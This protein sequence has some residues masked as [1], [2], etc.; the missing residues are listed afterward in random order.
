[1]IRPPASTDA[2]LSALLEDDPQALYDQAPCGFLSTAPDGLIVKVNQT[3]LRWA[4]FSSGDLV[5]QR[6]FASLLTK[7]GQIYYDTHYEPMLLMQGGVREIALELVTQS[8]QRMPVL[9]NAG[10]VRGPDGEPLV[11]R[12]VVF[13]ASERRQYEQELLRAKRR[14]EESEAR[15]RSLARTLQQALLPPHE[16]Q[17]PGLELAAAYQP[18][19]RGDEIAGDFYDIFQI[20]EE[21][22]VVTL[23]DVCGKGVDAAVLTS[24]VRHTLRAVT[25]RLP[26]PAAALRALNEVLLRHETDRFCTVALLRLRSLHGAWQ[27]TASLGG[28]PQPLSVTAEGAVGVLGTPGTLVWLFDDPRLEDSSFELEPGSTLLLYTDGVTE[29]RRGSDFYGDRRLRDLVAAHGGAPQELV[30]ALLLDVLDFQRGKPRDDIALVALGIAPAG[31]P[32]R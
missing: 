9:V 22:W 1:M 7:G 21:E 24:L 25:V 2:F 20:S 19:T 32:E 16:P 4:G 18:A 15:A 28:H 27:V 12:V 10:L 23:G 13:D 29:G 14:A 17:I 6:T 5:G 3:F 31:G 30:D 26:S 11:I 8:G